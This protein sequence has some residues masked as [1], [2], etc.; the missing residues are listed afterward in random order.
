[1]SLSL[2]LKSSA[3]LNGRNL[4]AHSPKRHRDPCAVW[5]CPGSREGTPNPGA[6]SNGLAVREADI[7]E[8]NACPVGPY[9]LLP[10]NR[11][12]TATTNLDP[13]P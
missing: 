6:G 2:D 1:M 5:G 10:V 4:G 12:S 9:P 8:W 7:S 3:Q 13:N 11:S